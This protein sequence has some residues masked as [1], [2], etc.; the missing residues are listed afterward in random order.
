MQENIQKSLEEIEK[1]ADEILGSSEDFDVEKAMKPED[2]VKDETKDKKESKKVENEKEEDKEKDKEEDEEKE[3]DED[4][5][6]TQKSMK[7]MI[8][9]NEEI[10]KSLDV[11][12][13]LS[14]IT[15]IQAKSI[16]GLRRDVAKSLK[17]SEQVSSV[18][19]KSYQAI[20]KSQQGLYDLIKSQ[21][22]ALQKQEDLIKSLEA[23]LDQVERQPVGRKA[24][25]DVVE[26]SFNQS[27]GVEEKLSKSQ[28]LAKMNSLFFS[29][30]PGI[31]VQDIIKYESE[32]VMSDNVRAL[33]NG[34]GA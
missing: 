34:G 15:R 1:Q 28:V 16:D 14:E 10:A 29:G 33:I 19:A 2:V 25:V 18:L 8:E 20:M 21:S 24:T 22:E 31:T 3:E 32:G 30:N 17:T 13:F 27:A 4:E 9:E 12:D 23:R 6:E 7:E 5:E 11:S 26:K